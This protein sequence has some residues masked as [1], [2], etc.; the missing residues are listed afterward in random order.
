MKLQRNKIKKYAILSLLATS[1]TLIVL[2]RISRSRTFQFFGEIYP[3]IQT[4]QKVVALTFDDG[5]T[6]LT[7]RVL[8]ILKELDIKATFFVTG[9][10]LVENMPQGKKIVLAGH[11]VG[12]HSYSHQ[13][14][15]LKTPAF[16]RAEIERTDSLIRRAGYRHEI[17]FRPP[18]GKKLVALPY[19]LEQTHRKTIMWDVEPESYAEIANDSKKIVSHVLANVKPG[20]IILLHVMVA[21][22]KESVQAIRGI[23]RQL[24]QRG[25]SFKTVSELLELNAN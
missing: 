9:K 8:P 7:D 21:E 15:V 19:Y 5:P 12:N 2:W 18:N 14:M 16:I 10:A 17:L 23:V 3:H 4:D 25:Y 20:S 13:R 11:Q 22:R 1:C 6:R 24:R